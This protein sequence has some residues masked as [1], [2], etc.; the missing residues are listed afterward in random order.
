MK[1]NYRKILENHFGIYD[2][3]NSFDLEAWT[4][5]G[6]DMFITIEKNKDLIS[7]LKDYVENFNI[8]EEIVRIKDNLEWAKAKGLTIIGAHLAGEKERNDLW[9]YNE[10]IIDLV[11]PYCDLVVT[12]ESSNYDGKFT[13]ISEEFNIP[14]IIV[15]NSLELYQIFQK[16]FKTR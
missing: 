14:L 15:N 12:H 3:E 11:V 4:N 9:H 8:D 2:D 1:N 5:G 10:K 13:V 7:Q 6:V 16:L